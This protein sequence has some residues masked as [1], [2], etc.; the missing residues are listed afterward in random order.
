MNVHVQCPRIVGQTLVDVFT[1]LAATVCETGSSKPKT[2]KPAANDQWLSPNLSNLPRSQCARKATARYRIA[3]A[4]IAA[5]II[6][7]GTA[8]C[9]SADLF[10]EPPSDRR[11]AVPEPITPA[12]PRQARPAPM[13]GTDEPKQAPSAPADKVQIEVKPP[14]PIPS[15]PPDRGEPLRDHGVDRKPPLPAMQPTAWAISSERGFQAAIGYVAPMAWFAVPALLAL[16]ILLNL[17]RIL[18]FVDHLFERPLYGSPSDALADDLQAEAVGADLV[19][20]I[21][22]LVQSELSAADYRKQTELLRAL[23]DKLDAEAEAARA[24]IR[25]E[26]ARAQQQQPGKDMP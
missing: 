2:I 15:P 6:V 14:S 18:R 10:F 20:D 13:V 16:L 8:G 22:D 25:R 26:R 3:I 19:L 24:T 7:G 11:W 23:K 9:R 17:R 4:I 21:R 5:C 1:M 12:K